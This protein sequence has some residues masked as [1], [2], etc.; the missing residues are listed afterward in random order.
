MR[1]AAFISLIV[2]L[3]EP[4]AAVTL[5]VG[6]SARPPGL[7][8]PYN[9]IS[10]V[11]SHSRATILDA[12]V[13]QGPD[14]TMEPALAAGWTAKSEL[15]WEFKIRP[16]AV[17]SNGEPADAA[18]VKATMDFLTQPDAVRF[19]MARELRAVARVDVIDPETLLVTTKYPDAIFPKR[20]S[21]VMIVPPRAFAEMGL[22]EFAQ[23]PIGSGSYLLEDWGLQTGRTI[24]TANLIS[25]RAPEQIDRVEVV[26][27]L[28]DSIV[29]LQALRSDQI[30]L[31]L[32]ISVD[33]MERMVAEG[34]ELSVE[35]VETVQAIA[36]PNVGNPDSP[37]QDV[38]VRQA[39]NYAVNKDIITEIILGGTTHPTGQGAIPS[40]VGYNPDIEPYPYDPDRAKALLA[41]AGYGDG[42]A[43]RA[44]LLRGGAPTDDAVY[45]QVAQDL[46]RV[47]IHMELHNLI[48]QEW[49]LKFFSGDWG[50][51]DVLSMTWTTGAYSDT[52]RA[53][54]TFSCEKPGRSFVRLN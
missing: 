45:V 40:S 41:E 29:R 2:L 52:I 5:R 26:A 17:F 47:G 18:A 20:M 32:N 27:P 7:G 10:T 51:A 48:G 33:E 24:L 49:I 8:N 53:I 36:L 1:F 21:L 34:F 4:A 13:R 54:E 3:A 6:A 16:G 46:A 31:T 30:D 9:S 35:L 15:E 42:F 14:G 50:D 25:W 37:M 19:L 38:R 44:E 23:A 39:M 22:D 28:R 43:L 12:L 11:G